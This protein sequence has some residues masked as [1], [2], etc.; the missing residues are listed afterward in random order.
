MSHHTEHTAQTYKTYYKEKLEG[1]LE[2]Q[3]FVLSTLHANGLS[4]VQFSSKKYQIEHGETS[5]GIEIK[6]DEMYK[7]TGNLYIE[8]AEKAHPSNKNYAYSGIYRN[9][10]SWLYAIGDYETFF[11]FAKS[12]L[13]LLHRSK[14]HEYQRKEIPTSKGFLLPHKDAEK[15]AAK[16]FRMAL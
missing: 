15:F 1:A 6:H 10:N 12:T 7:K 8:I 9:D 14:T 3:D 16:V 11:I 2:F 4:V 5:G 13:K